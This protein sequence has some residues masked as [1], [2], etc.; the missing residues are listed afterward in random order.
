MSNTLSNLNQ[1]IFN[2]IRYGNKN[3][4]EY[5]ISYL[6]LLNKKYSYPLFLTSSDK[7][8]VNFSYDI[9]Y[10]LEGDRYDCIDEINDL[11]K[12]GFYY[13][14]RDI[15]TIIVLKIR[16]ERIN[17]EFNEMLDIYYYDNKVILEMLDDKLPIHLWGYKYYID[18]KKLFRENYL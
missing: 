9:Y 3:Y 7:E 4:K 10:T 8:E 15:N 14:Y 13:S 16:N 17:F 2:R 5:D 12:D 11:I 6:I 1:E 18:N